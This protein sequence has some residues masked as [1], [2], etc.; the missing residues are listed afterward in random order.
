ME[1]HCQRL[2]QNYENVAT[3]NAALAA[4]HRQMAREATE[5]KQ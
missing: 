5:K 4:A 2:A 3:E 1:G